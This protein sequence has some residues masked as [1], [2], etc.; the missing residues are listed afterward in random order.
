MT[1]GLQRFPDLGKELRRPF[2]VH[3]H[4]YDCAAFYDGC[5]AWP[6]AKEFGCG[7]YQRLPDVMSGAFG[8]EFPE[9]VF[10][11]ANRP[12]TLCCSFEKVRAMRTTGVRPN[13]IPQHR[14]AT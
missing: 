7:H 11:P 13:L 12:P 1:N 10:V 14:C 6:A 8:Q 3:E 2:S 5:E 4:C 9:K